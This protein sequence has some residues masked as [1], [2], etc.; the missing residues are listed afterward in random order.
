MLRKAA[1]RA[2]ENSG[3]PEKAVIQYRKALESQPNDA[4]THQWLVGV[5]KGMQKKDALPEALL[6][7]HRAAPRD[8]SVIQQLEKAYTELMLDDQAERAA[9]MLVESQPLEA[10][11]HQAMA[12][13]RQKQGRWEEAVP[14][15]R[16]VAEL[17]ELEPTGLLGLAKAQAHLKQT[18]AAKQTVAK[19]LAK[20]WPERFGNVHDQARRL[21]R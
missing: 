2:Y 13:L 12:E 11:A 7:W 8:V 20:N 1:G 18:D 15:W 21:L 4:E 19:L 16:R 17:R 9:T 3:K 10:S 14:H 5:L 6:A